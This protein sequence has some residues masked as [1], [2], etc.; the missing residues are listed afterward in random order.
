MKS[1][2][3]LCLLSGGMDSA[4]TAF[5]AAQNHDV[6]TIFFRYGQ[7]TEAKE[8]NCFRELSRT[9]GAENS[10]I[11]DLPFYRRLGG[12]ALTDD[13][14]AIPDHEDEGI[15]PTYVPFRNGIML[16][17]A[18]AHAEVL[19]IDNL[20]IGAVWEYS[21]GYPDC[22]EEFLQAMERAI[23]L[24][25]GPEFRPKINFPVIDMTKS[26]IIKR[27]MELSV[28]FE[29]TWSCYSAEDRPCGVCPSCRLRL[30]AF[31]QTGLTD[32]LM[33]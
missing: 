2:K 20:F 32:P 21:S 5:I 17:I 11:V 33:R 7:P 28:P 31:Q 3:A 29:H 22:R 18:S 1:S 30:R 10:I 12:S 26:Q 15:P 13:T 14:I 9:L 6:S 19:G 4:V 16:S 24:G 27:G 23:D 8:L 25:T